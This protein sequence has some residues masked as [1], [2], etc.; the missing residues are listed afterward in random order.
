MN[1]LMIIGAGVT[2]VAAMTEAYFDA[3]KK[4]VNHTIS[5]IVRVVLAG[6]MSIAITK[7]WYPQVIYATI[8]LVVYWIC[9]DIMYNA[10][11]RLDLWYIGSTS[12]LDKLA[13]KVFKNGRSYL[14]CKVWLLFVLIVAFSI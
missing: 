6:A 12:T 11:R 10:S 3:K 4:S 7:E 9:F 13:K 2:A 8:L 14:F 5:A 1:E